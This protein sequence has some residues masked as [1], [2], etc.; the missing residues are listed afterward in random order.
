[1]R[2]TATRNHFNK[3]HKHVNKAQHLFLTQHQ[4]NITSIGR[5]K[6]QSPTAGVVGVACVSDAPVVYVNQTTSVRRDS[7]RARR[8]RARARAPSGRATVGWAS[9]A[10][11]CWTRRRTPA[12]ARPG[13]APHG[14]PPPTEMYD[15][16]PPLCALIDT[17][18]QPVLCQLGD[19]T[20]QFTLA[21]VFLLFWR[22][23]NL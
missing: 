8:G 14:T 6:T 4:T 21:Q 15:S 16:Q 7:A 19:T 10:R 23:V 17:F 1:M 3:K 12:A 9:R 18:T 5:S 13:R 11:G 22:K 2:V 20:C